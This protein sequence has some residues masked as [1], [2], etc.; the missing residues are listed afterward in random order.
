MIYSLI[1][2]ELNVPESINPTGKITMYTARQDNQAVAISLSP[3]VTK[4]YG[5]NMQLLIG[6]SVDG[7]LLGV[8]YP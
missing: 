4:G 1:T 2:R 5:G 6:I 8:T 7:K 3:I